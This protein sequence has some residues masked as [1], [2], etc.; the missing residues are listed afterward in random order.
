MKLSVPYT[1]LLNDFFKW[2]INVR[3]LSEETLKTYHHY[4]IKFLEQLGANSTLK[5][6]L[7]LSP[8]EIQTSFLDYSKNHGLR[9]RRSMK[10][11]LRTFFRFC[12]SQGY[13]T[14]NPADSIPT[15]RTYKLSTLPRG[16]KD[17]D[18]QHVLSN[19]DRT[20]DFGKRDYAIIQMLYTYGVRGGQVRKLR[21]DDINWEQSKILFPVLKHGKE[22]ILPLT[23]DVGESLLD[24]LQHSRPDVPYQ[25]VFLT[26]HPSHIPICDSRR[27]SNIIA[28]RMRAANIKS[29][30]LGAHVFR[31]CFAS[32]M[33]NHGHPLKS[34]ADM[35]GHRCISSTFIYTKVDFQTL[36][37]VPLEWPE[38]KS[39]EH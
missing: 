31:H 5:K 25:E 9:A 20:T 3:N 19:I 18:A 34:I 22:C 17:K 2:M 21:F 7:S 23:E 16:I 6:L 4:L 35:L 37:Q 28:Y 33:L 30:T 36:N 27:F 29:S 24:Y 8:N 26:M 11:T 32:R 39:C 10:A 38:G 13:I 14:C 1:S 15:L 12:L